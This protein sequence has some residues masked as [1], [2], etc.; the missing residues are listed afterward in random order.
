MPSSLRR[1]RIQLNQSGT[2]ILFASMILLRLWSTLT[3]LSVKDRGLPEGCSLPIH[4]IQYSNCSRSHHQHSPVSMSTKRENQQK[5]QKQ[6]KIII[7][8]KCRLC[9]VRVFKTIYTQTQCTLTVRHFILKIFLSA[10]FYQRLWN[11]S[12]MYSGLVRTV[13]QT[14]LTCILF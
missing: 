2:L 13:L 7:T 11:Q 12:E 6:N 9:D 1:E 14:F 5:H 8:H 3:V 4:G 10:T